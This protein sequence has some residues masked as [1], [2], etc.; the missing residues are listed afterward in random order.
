MPSVASVRI[1]APIMVSPVMMSPDMAV[2]GKMF[3][4]ESFWK[5]RILLLLVEVL[6]TAGTLRVPLALVDVTFLVVYSL[7]LTS[8]LFALVYVCFF[9][10]R[11][12]ILTTFF[13]IL[14]FC[15][16]TV[17][18]IQRGR[19]LC[20]RCHS[21]LLLFFGCFCLCLVCHLFASFFFTS[22]KSSGEKMW[23]EGCYLNSGRERNE[24]A[25][26]EIL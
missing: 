5:T 20:L 8:F 2:L 22:D 25:K 13:S 3:V 16:F 14:Q 6:K 18:W 9:D 23:C 10:R 4:R 7:F 24:K 17:I 12:F 1:S 19:R 21:R 15:C 11:C 26:N